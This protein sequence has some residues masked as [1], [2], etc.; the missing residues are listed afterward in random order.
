MS[1]AH[2]I[3]N[4]IHSKDYFNAKNFINEA[5]MSKMANALEEKLVHFAPTLFEAKKAK[6][7]YDKDGNVESSSAEF[8]GSR[9][10]AIKKAM[11]M[12]EDWTSDITSGYDLTNFLNQYQQTGQ[13]PPELAAFYQ[14]NPPMGTTKKKKYPTVSGQA[15]TI[16]AGY[17]PSNA[18]IQEEWTDQISDPMALANSLN[19]YQNTGQMPPEL[20]AFY[21]QNPPVQNVKKKKY[22]TVSGQSQTINAGYEPNLDTLAEAFE[23]DLMEMIQEIEESTGDKLTEKEISEIAQ[24]YLSL[25]GEMSEEE[26]DEE[27]DDEDDI[28]EALE[29]GVDR[30][31]YPPRAP[32][33]LPSKRPTRYP[34]VSRPGP[35]AVPGAGP[36]G[37]RPGTIEYGSDH[38]HTLPLDIQYHYHQIFGNQELIP[39]GYNPTGFNPPPSGL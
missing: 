5:L 17:E 13:M 39:P 12:K 7:D 34:P 21:Q 28:A 20:V 2:D 24:Q 29:D 3:L 33:I 1:N 18:G 27:E 16:N 31:T 6:K 14:Q 15:Q 19:T 23:Q 25:L 10:K 11:A 32:S 9:D 30:V 37:R 26:Y 8:L 4:S 22:P 35:I 36:G 38:F